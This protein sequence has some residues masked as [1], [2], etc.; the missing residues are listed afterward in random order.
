MCRIA[1]IASLNLTADSCDAVKSM[2]QSMKHGGPDDSGWYFDDH[3]ALG[4]RRLAII[5]LSTAGHQPMLLAD[6]LVISFNGEIYNY[7]TLRTELENTG[8]VF[9][10]RSD[11]EVILQAYRKW[12]SGSFDRFEGIFA[13]ALFDKTR[14][15]LLLARDHVGVKPLYY[16]MDGKELIFASEIRAFHAYRKD[17]KE[18]ENWKILFLAFGSIPYPYTTLNG[19]FLLQ[20]GCFIELNLEDFTHSIREYKSP[21]KTQTFSNHRQEIEAMGS[22]IRGAVKKNLISDAPLGVFLSG[23]IDSSLLALVADQLQDGVKTISINFDDSEFDEYPFQKMVLEKTNNVEHTSY[24]VTEK[25]FW[26]SLP[27]IWSAMDQPT[28]DGV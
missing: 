27:D 12:G 11:T 24:R 22:A 21:R 4:H 20:P 3:V 9:T 16:F 7:E 14:K 19:V 10:T 1:G 25:M 17:W 15:K 8:A 28:I 13:F 26:D 6:E 2:T 5:D 18:N 23:G